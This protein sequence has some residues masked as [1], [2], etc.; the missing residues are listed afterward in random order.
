MCLILARN[1]GN[2]KRHSI[3][4]IT[5]IEKS[6]RDNNSQQNP[7][8]LKINRKQKNTHFVAT[9]KIATTHFFLLL[10]S[11]AMPIR[12]HTYPKA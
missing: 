10:P 12:G 1:S 3:R 7:H 4:T 6:V 5:Q 11:I 9:S 2:S 8:F